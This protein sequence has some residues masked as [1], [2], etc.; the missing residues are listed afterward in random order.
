MWVFYHNVSSLSALNQNEPDLLSPVGQAGIVISVL[1]LTIGTFL[2][3]FLR[4]K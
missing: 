3:I 1:I 4:G 2:P